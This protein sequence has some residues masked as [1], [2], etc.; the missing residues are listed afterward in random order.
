VTALGVAFALYGSHGHAQTGA[1]PFA[2]LAGS[3]AGSGTILL[4][5]GTTE[6]LRCQAAYMV[7]G[8]GSNL[9]QSLRCASDTYNFDLR[10]SVDYAGGVISGTWVEVG[11]NVQGRISGTASGGRIEAVAQGP[12]FSAGLGIGTRGNRQSVSIRSAGTELAQ[13]SITLSRTR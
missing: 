13:V 1:S 10:T 5:N 3:W 6:R 12:G 7:A 9:R 4:S 8:A 2:G 11:R